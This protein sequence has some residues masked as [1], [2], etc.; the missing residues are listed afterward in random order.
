VNNC[1]ALFFSQGSK[2]LRQKCLLSL[3][4]ER[5][6]EGDISHAVPDIRVQGAL[7]SVYCCL[8]I[9]QYKLIKGLLDHNIGEKLENFKKE[10][11]TH[12]QDPKIQV[13]HC[14]FT[15]QLW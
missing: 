14:S 12:M 6:L 13:M 1:Y 3:K 2:L 8:N 11:L 10:L 4:I 7:S 5:N 9:E 15:I